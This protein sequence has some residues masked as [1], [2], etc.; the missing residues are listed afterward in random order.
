M[1]RAMN[2]YFEELISLGE[3]RGHARVVTV[4]QKGAQLQKE[5]IIEIEEKLK[6]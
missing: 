4:R 1:V 2:M 6:G 3:Q 5:F